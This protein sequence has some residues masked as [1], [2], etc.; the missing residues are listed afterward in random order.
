[1]IKN[2]ATMAEQMTQWRKAHP[3][4]DPPPLPRGPYQPKTSPKDRA[5]FQRLAN[6]TLRQEWA[7]LVVDILADLDRAEAALKRGGQ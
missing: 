5:E 6:V 3:E 7:E 4:H 2:G 1:M